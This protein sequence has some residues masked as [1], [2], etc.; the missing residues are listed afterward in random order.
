[1]STSYVRGQVNDILLFSDLKVDIETLLTTTIDT[2]FRRCLSWLRGNILNIHLSFTILMAVFLLL[3][4]LC[5]ADILQNSGF[6]ALYGKTDAAGETDCEGADKLREG[7]AV[8]NHSP[9]NMEEVAR[10]I[11][12]VF[13]P[14]A[15]P[16]TAVAEMSWLST[17]SE[18]KHLAQA[19]W[20]RNL[21]GVGEANRIC[22]GNALTTEFP[23]TFVH[24]NTKLIIW[25][26]W[27]AFPLLRR[28][29]GC[30]WPPKNNET[31]GSWNVSGFSLTVYS[32]CGAPSY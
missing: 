23:A 20:Q 32:L 11:P 1:M 30:A 2:I 25:G 13:E 16:T 21:P 14:T 6:R 22:K 28:G 27:L 5:R 4:G 12:K 18:P 15:V 8:S 10:K 31:R 24:F 26:G 19:L 7:T 29:S 9:K 17:C 3:E